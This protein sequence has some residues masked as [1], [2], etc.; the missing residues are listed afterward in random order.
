MVDF[1]LHPKVTHASSA[2]W[3]LQREFKKKNTWLKG[4]ECM[5]AIL[6]K[7]SVLHDA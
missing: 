5:R 6:A 4:W 7:T 2:N 3:K 1:S